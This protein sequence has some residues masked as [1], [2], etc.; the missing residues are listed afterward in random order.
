M[1]TLKIGWLLAGALAIA[2]VVVA[3]LVYARFRRDIRAARERLTSG[4]SQVIETNCGPI[5]YATVGEGPPVLV[6][7][8]ILGGF[9]QGLVIARGNVGEGF[10]SIVPS[11]FGYLRTPLPADASPAGQADAFACLLDAL[12]IQQAA[13][14]GTSAG[15]TSAIQFALRHPDRCSALVLFSSA[16]PGETDAALPPEPLA[17]MMFK[18]DLL[19]WLV[20]TYFRSSLSS[21]MG[22]PKGFELTPE[23]E[24]DVAE[25]MTTI[26]PVNPRSDGAVFDMFVSN[27]DVN[28]GYP[29]GEIAAPVLIV[30]AV[31]DPLTLYVNAQTLAERVPGARLVTIEDG[32]HMMLGHEERVRSEISGFLTGVFD[33]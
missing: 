22:V 26:L 27:P 33:E 15:G 30:N 8:G 23:Y 14:L 28:T 21:I 29:V 31:D 10:R 18:S 24:D 3:V 13:V 17:R 9:D 12:G 25:V 16:A 1:G 19:F 2:V 7:H 4:G 6:V 32:G 20:T 11:R 5:E